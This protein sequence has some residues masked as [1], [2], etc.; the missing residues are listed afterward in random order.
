M[1]ALPRRHRIVTGIGSIPARPKLSSKRSRSRRHRPM[2]GGIVSGISDV[3]RL[4]GVSKST[5]SRALTGQR[6]RLRRHP[7]PGAGRRARRSGYVASSNAASLV[8]GRTRNIGVIMPYLNRWFFAEV[9]EGIQDA[10]LE[11]GLDLTLYD[12]RPGIARTAA[13]LRGLPGAQAVRRAHRRR[14]RAGGPR[15]RDGSS[16]VGRPIVS[17]VGV[18]G[19]LQRHRRS[20]TT[21]PRAAPPST[22]SRSDTGASPSSAATRTTHWARVDRRRLDG[23]I[24]GDD[25]RRARAR[26]VPHPLGRSRCRAATPRPSTC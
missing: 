6:L 4:A 2:E 25:R 8:T 21:Q 16:R 5:A 19:R 15:A 14:P 26:G 18:G 1:V 9:L 10:L 24:A 12:A 7:R 22:C 23:Y 13:D 20:T 17:V 3:A 11:H